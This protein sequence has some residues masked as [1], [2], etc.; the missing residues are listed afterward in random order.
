VT[1][2]SAEREAVA[3]RAAEQADL[4]EVFRIERACFPEPWPFSAFES[5]LDAPA[6]LVAERDLAIRGY[7]VGDVTPNYGRDIGHVKDLAVAP[8][9]RERGLGRRL[10]TEALARMAAG[11]AT[12]VKLEVRESN[13]VARALYADVG[14]ESV[15]RVP[16][17]Y[18]DGEDAVVMA[19]SVDDWQRRRHR[20]RGDAGADGPNDE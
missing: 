16:R 11:G 4:L 12:V 3:I 5:F 19:L 8:D 15:R 7:V 6:F 17:Y 13:D 20:E 1:T 9:A 18:D 14:F 2:P 10:L